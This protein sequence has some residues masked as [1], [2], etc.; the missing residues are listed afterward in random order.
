MRKENLLKLLAMYKQDALIKD[1]G[2]MS[3]H[4]Q[5]IF[6]KN[7]GRLDIK[8]VFKLHKRFSSQ[9]HVTP[10]QQKYNLHVSSQYL[11]QTEKKGWNKKRDR[12]ER[13][14]SKTERLPFL[15]WPEA[16]DQGSVLMV[17]KDS[18]R[19]RRLRTKLSFSF[20]PSK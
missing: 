14:S 6:L 11:K 19:F 3:P 13:S 15:S 20:L 18:T 9:D 4:Q 2:G 8:L 17:L 1:Y 7:L 12:K 5:N 10:M 16:K